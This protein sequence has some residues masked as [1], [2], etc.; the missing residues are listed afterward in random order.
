VDTGDKWAIGSKKVAEEKK[1]VAE[2]VKV[3]QKIVIPPPV[4]VK[5]EEKKSVFVPPPPTN[6]AAEKKGKWV[7]AS[8]S[9]PEK[10]VE[11]KK[12]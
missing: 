8:G 3:E 4:Q 7:D 1:E 11:E 9:K 5:V 6:P 2:P 10:K 12:P